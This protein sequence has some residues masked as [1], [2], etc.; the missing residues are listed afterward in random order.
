MAR[1]AL[2]DR[3]VVHAHAKSLDGAGA[4]ELV[5]RTI[6]A[7]HGLC[8]SLFQ[9]VALPALVDV[10]DQNDVERIGAESLQ[11]VLDGAHRAVVAIVVADL[12][13]VLAAG[14]PVRDAAV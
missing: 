7:R 12:E 9:H 13:G 8:V 6:G 2:E 10:V 4:A 14:S 3:P 11:A 5:E 1:E